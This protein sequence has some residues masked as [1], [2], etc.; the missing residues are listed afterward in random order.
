[1]VMPG[2]VAGIYA[3]EDFAE[4]DI[5]AAAP[6]ATTKKT[7]AAKSTASVT[8]A[9]VNNAEVIDVEAEKPAE[10]QAAQS[11][12]FDGGTVQSTTV[13]A[14]TKEG[15][16]ANDITTVLME[17]EL[18]LGEIG[19]TKAD[20]E[21]GMKKKNP[22]FTTIDDLGIDQAKQILDRLRAKKQASPPA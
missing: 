17:I 7:A 5:P 2:I 22:A 4:G 21:A 10:T 14:T 8:A 16:S 15:D 13:A 12:P 6:V 11:A 18:V 1:M 20:L 9:T 3:P 19:M